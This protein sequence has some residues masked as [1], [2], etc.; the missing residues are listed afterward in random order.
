MSDLLH[1]CRTC[2]YD[3]RVGEHRV[4]GRGSDAS[5]IVLHCRVPV[6]SKPLAFHELAFALNWPPDI[7]PDVPGGGA[8]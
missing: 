3:E 4:I 5:H 8:V 7:G 2:G 6:G 1:A